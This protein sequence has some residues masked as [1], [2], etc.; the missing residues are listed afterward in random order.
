M[1]LE[2]IWFVLVGVL[3]CG[4][5]ILDGFDLGV[6]MLH[7]FVARNDGERRMVLNAIGPVWDG[8]EVW[9]LTGGGAIFAAFPLVYATVFSGFYLALV[10]LLAAL[11]VRAVALEWRSKESGPGWR[12]GWDVAIAASSALPPLLFGVAVGNVVRG[13]PLTA[14]LEFAGSFVGLLNPFALLV[15]LLSVA[16]M[17]QQGTSWLLLKTEGPV[18]ARVRRA[19]PWVWLAYVGLWAVSL[20]AS[21]PAVPQVWLSYEHP[22]AWI[23]PALFVLSEVATYGAL[24]RQKAGA[25]M[26]LSSGSIGALLLTAAVGLYPNLVPALGSPGRG[27]TIANASSSQLTLTVML[28]I[29]LLGMPL[30]IGYTAFI[31]SRFR[32]PVRLDEHSY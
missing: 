16:M 18:A 12:R 30:V 27:L 26:L 10:L 32:G 2:T 13:I 1:L 15:G 14:D 31:Y 11:M 9:L 17:L 4:Y 28:V 3:L 8:N 24:R 7:L 6:G 19:A 23:G 5:A 21:I 20:L 22:L 29:A 25:G